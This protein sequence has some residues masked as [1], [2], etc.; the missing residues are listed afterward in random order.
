MRNSRSSDTDS[1]SGM[2]GASQAFSEA[3]TT[4]REDY[5]RF[6]GLRKEEG[7]AAGNEAR[8]DESEDEQASRAN[9]AALKRDAGAARRRRHRPRP[10]LCFHACTHQS[11]SPTCAAAVSSE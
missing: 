6:L 11:L 7:A 1:F 5:A 8:A 10:C 4:Y 3:V 9:G 2:P